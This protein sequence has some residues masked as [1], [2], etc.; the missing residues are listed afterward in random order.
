MFFEL[1]INGFLARTNWFLCDLVKQSATELL[2]EN[3]RA[4]K[5]QHPFRFLGC[6]YLPEKSCGCLSLPEL[7]T[8]T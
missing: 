2:I 7:N 4:G 1:L 5:D 8:F 6:L 3:L